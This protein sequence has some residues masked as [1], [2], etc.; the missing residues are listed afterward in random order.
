MARTNYERGVEVERKA[1]AQLEQVGYLA[2][3][4]AGSHGE[5]DV[6]AVNPNGVRFIQCKR[7]KEKLGNWDILLDQLREI[8]VPFNAT[9]ELWVWVDRKGWALQEV[10]K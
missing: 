5:W 2:Y 9:K 4:T 7:E 8:K 3:R 1:I 6:I 10:V